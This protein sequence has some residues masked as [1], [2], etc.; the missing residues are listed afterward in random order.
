[1]N[2]TGFQT[3]VND[4]LPIGIAGDWASANPRSSAIGGP[5]AFVAPPG[6]TN[7]GAFA[8][9]DPSTGLATNY[10]K[11]NAFG[12][13]V[14]RN[15]QAL[16][17]QFLGIATTQVVP[18]NMVS[19]HNQGDFYGIFQAGAAILQKVYADPVTGALSGNVT[20]DSVTGGNTGASITSGVLTTTDADATG[21]AAAVGQL[22]TGDTIPEGTYLASAGAVGGGLHAWN[23]A[24]VNGTAIP[25]A[26]TFTV[27]LYGVQETQYTVASTVAVDATSS[28]ASL[29]VTGVLT[30]GGSV[31]GVFTAGQFISDSGDIP[32]SA[33][34]QILYQL[35][36]GTVGG[37]G[38]YQTN[39]SPPTAITSEALTATAGKIGAVTSW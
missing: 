14:H 9:A 32:V 37:A 30:I 3:F 29:A 10:Y 1:M 35:P 33:N 38:T 21:T 25:N 15:N 20:G 4:V 18:G 31:T 13:I 28:A 24:N 12:G 8:W 34:A 36:G 22:V 5:G 11:P 19:V 26:T 7:V 23:L 27:A 17:T 2:R 39:Y 6:G 16:I